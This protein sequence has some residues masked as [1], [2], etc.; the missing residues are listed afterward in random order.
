MP[1]D[2]KSATRQS[3]KANREAALLT[4][5]KNAPTD[6]NAARTIQDP[7]EN[8]DL[9][10]IIEPPFDL[11]GLSMLLEQNSELGQCIDAMEVNISGY[12]WRL[13]RDPY[14][15]SA[16][17]DELARVEYERFEQFL[18]YANY[19]EGSFVS[20]RR[21]TR[22]AMESTG[23]AFWEVVRNDSGE[24]SAFNLIPTYTMR[25]CPVGHE[26]LTVDQRRPVGRGKD[27]RFESVR[28]RKK[29]RK[30][31][32]MKYNYNNDDQ[33][34]QVFFKQYGD[35]RPM[36]WASG[37]Y[38]TQEQIE[39]SQSTASPITQDMLA[40]EVMHWRL[41]CSRSPYGV[42][43][44][45]G[46]LLAITGSRAAEEINF[47][48]FKNN[49]IPSMAVLVSNGMLTEGTIERITQFVETTIQG[50]DNY[51]KFLVIEAEG[52]A[53][54]DDPSQVKLELKP[55]TKEQHTDELFQNY[56]KNADDRTRR[57]FRLAPI[58]VGRSD[59]YTRSTAD[60]SRK[61]TDEQVF[62]PERQE[63]DHVL[64][65]VLRDM[66][67][68]YH[69]FSTSSPNVTD[70][71]DLIAVLTGGEKTGGITPRISRMIIED[72]LGRDLGEISSEIRADVPFSLQMAEAVKN[73]ALP[74]EVG[75]QVTALKRELLEEA[76][77]DPGLIDAIEKLNARS[78]QYVEDVIVDFG[79]QAFML[80]DK[81]MSGA[82]SDVAMDL[83][84]RRLFVSD[85][86]EAVAQVHFGRSRRMDR[87]E[88]AKAVGLP[89]REI[90]ELF[91]SKLEVF[92][93]NV[94]GV[95]P[96][97]KPRPYQ[98]PENSPFAVG[99]LTTKTPDAP[100]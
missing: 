93:H 26:W 4:I 97:A 30:F 89:E 35:P 59:D 84:G 46:H 48:T 82:I 8:A 87:A 76:G 45:I 77:V 3:D 42:P 5:I 18:I 94:E 95:Q 21:Q 52:E 78:D 73:L 72:I 57:A 64:N 63:E 14:A 92:V 70:D 98:H 23:N 27:R 47:T 24:I 7:W 85:G 99:M 9:N 68:L 50:S 36:L 65:R 33:P 20:L 83:D 32:Q 2:L 41:H 55:L 29:F 75:A 91:P 12:G 25:L 100:T 69:V 37:Q 38:I 71:E 39:Q 66:G 43:R 31:M 44:F 15:V 90:L 79:P 80:A 88:A 40:S 34:Q 67:M 10:G 60:T 62:D 13:K 28:I 54:G 86:H 49:N 51:S 56:A 1:S 19:D 11:L 22:K 96:L 61:L 74:N 6:Q 58:F 53:E 16:E 81:S 17:L